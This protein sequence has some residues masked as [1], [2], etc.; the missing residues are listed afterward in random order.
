MPL[1]IYQYSIRAPRISRQS[2]IVSGVFFVSK[3]LLGIKEQK[4]LNEIVILS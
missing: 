4:E 3:S 2:S 1:S